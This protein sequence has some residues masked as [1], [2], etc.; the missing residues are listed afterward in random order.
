MGAVRIL[1]GAHHF[2]DQACH[3]DW[4]SERLT[5]TLAADLRDGPLLLGPT[6]ADGYPRSIRPGPGST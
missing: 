2:Y 1:G 5:K 6:G 4:T 3:I